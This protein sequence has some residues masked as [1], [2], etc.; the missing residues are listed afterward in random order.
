MINSG[1]G[2]VVITAAPDD[3]G[4]TGSFSLV[5]TSATVRAGATVPLTAEV[6]LDCSRSPALDLP[7]LRMDLVGGRQRDLPVAGVLSTVLRLCS[8]GARNLRPVAVTSEQIVGSRLVLDRCR[9][10]RSA[11]FGS[12]SSEPAAFR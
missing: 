12:T 10:H 6:L 7:P 5:P 2:D 8:E 4:R 11:R 9:P 1:P 3:G